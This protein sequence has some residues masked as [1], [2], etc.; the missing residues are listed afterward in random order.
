MS[1]DRKPVAVHGPR[2]LDGAGGLLAAV[3]Q[4]DGLR[5]QMPATAALVDELRAAL[6]A[7]IVDAILRA[8][9]RGE[10]AFYAAELHADG[11]LREWGRAPSGRRAVV[12]GGR[13]VL[14][15]AP[16]GRRAAP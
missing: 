15:Q 7:T 4:G 5:V 2:A 3:P 8:T 1:A 6:G 10:R 14:A 11:T 13:V 9:K 12:Q 16:Q